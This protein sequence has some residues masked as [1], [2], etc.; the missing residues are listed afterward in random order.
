MRSPGSEEKKTRK[1]EVEKAFE[2]ELLFGVKKL[3]FLGMRRISLPVKAI[4]E[5]WYFCYYLF[6]FYAI[7]FLLIIKSLHI[8]RPSS[9][10]CY[11]SLLE[12][13]KWTLD[14]IDGKCV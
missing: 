2:K 7:V 6:Y 10:A 8:L 12:I 3:L 14:V 13:L 5:S 4:E 11:S 1:I 9:D